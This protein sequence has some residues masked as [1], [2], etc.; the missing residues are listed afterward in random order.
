MLRNIP[1]N[2]QRDKPSN[3]QTNRSTHLFRQKAVETPSVPQQR[4]KQLPPIYLLYLCSLWCY[5]TVGTQLFNLTYRP[6]IS[7]LRSSRMN[8]CRMKRGD[9]LNG[10][11]HIILQ[12]RF[13]FFFFFF[14]YTGHKVTSSYCCRCF[15][16]IFLSGTVLLT[17]SFSCTSL[18]WFCWA[19]MMW[20][21]WWKVANQPPTST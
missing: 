12:P 16:K 4:N 10:N 19:G 2:K 14:S 5:C 9:V 20:R 6:K 17:D 18:T 3:K 7:P 11:S 13:H 8:Y 15:K 21:D 1:I